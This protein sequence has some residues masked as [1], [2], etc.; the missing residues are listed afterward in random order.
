MLKKY[1]IDDSKL[2][3]IAVIATMSSG[4]STFINALIGE[5][6]LPSQN[7]ACTAK[8]IPILDN[9]KAES[10]RAYVEYTDS[11]KEIFNL[12]DVNIIN[13]FNFNT[14]IKDILIEGNIKGIRNSS[15]AS[16]LIDT[17]GT[18]FSGDETHKDQTYKLIEALDEGMILYLINA[19]Q[20][21]INDDLELLIHINDKVKKTKGKLKI[22]FVVNKIDE[23]DL[24]K[25]DIKE[26][27]KEIQ[28]YLINN[29]INEPQIVPISALAAKLFKMALNERTLTRRELREFDRYYDLFK[30]KGYDLTKYALV[31]DLDDQDKHIKVGE[32]TL[33]K[34]NILRAIENTGIC[35]VEELIEQYLIN[36]EEAFN[37]IVNFS[38]RKPK[39]LNC[40]LKINVIAAM[41]SGKSTLINSF[42]GHELLPSN[43]MACT[44]TIARIT[45]NNDVKKFT[46]A[47]KDENEKIVYER[48]S[49]KLEDIQRY[50][51]DEKI[52]YIDIEGPVPNISSEKMNILLVDTPGPNNSKGKEYGKFIDTII[53]V[54]NSIVLY[55]MSVTQMGINDDSE[56]LYMISDAM[57]K[58]G[59]Q[60]K[61]RFFFVMNKC[62]QYD[63]EK[64]ESIKG[65]LKLVTEYLAGYGI[66]EPKVFLVSAETAKLIRMHKNGIEITRKEQYFLKVY[67]DFNDLEGHHFEKFSTLSESSRKKLELRL[68]KAKYENNAYEEALIHTGIP[69]VEEAINEYMDNLLIKE[70]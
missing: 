56:M 20:F 42:I 53:K 21:G 55:V 22:L 45:V 28:N 1:G 40:T 54:G 69:A 39:K 15:R 19:T 5:D 65:L 10:F 2:F 32:N 58:G 47:C 9:D 31:K 23:F 70:V 64:G 34:G 48:N 63:C 8:I 25:E 35:F 24:E 7:Q 29:G 43:N 67:E 49:V 62:D 17:P 33:K 16:V 4:K 68:L 60:F 27:M 12:S 36:T 18:N 3:K 44:A 46:A 38:G 37:P 52:T 59:K 6:I 26:T 61:D 14:N 50:N 66:Q 30:P 57:K 11:K 51:Q 13:E 41:S